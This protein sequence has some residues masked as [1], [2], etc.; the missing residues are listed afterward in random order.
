[1]KNSNK[2]IVKSISNIFIT[3]MLSVQD[4]AKVNGGIR[5]KP[6]SRDKDHLDLDDD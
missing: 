1:M 2:Y 3:E 4:L 5:R 6:K